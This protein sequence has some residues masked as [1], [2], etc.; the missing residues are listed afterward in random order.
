MPTAGSPSLKRK[1]VVES[2]SECYRRK[3]KC[4]RKQP[5]NNCSVRNVPGKCT[6]N[7]S[8]VSRP[9]TRIQRPSMS[10][11]EVGQGQLPI[12][13]D[14]ESPQLGSG[15]LGYSSV[16]GSNAFVG[17]QQILGN[18]EFEKM[19]AVQSSAFNSR[20]ARKN[21]QTLVSKLPPRPVLQTLVNVFF[22]EVNWH[23]AI[24]ERFYFDDLFSR[25][26]HSE[27]L[28]PVNYLGPEELSRELRYF[29]ALL[30]QV[31]S[32][33]LQVLPPNHL[34]MAQISAD[35]LGTSQTYSDLGDELLSVL[36]RPGATLSGVQADFLRSSWLKNVGRGTEAWHSFGNAIRQAQELGLHRQREI[37]QPDE[38]NISK[39]LSCLW[40][41]ENKKR[42]WINLFVWDSFMAMILGRPRMIHR[43]D[44]DAKPP[45]ECSIPKNP[46]T[47]VPMAVRL[48][49]NPGII[50]VSASLFRYAI[51]CKVHDMRAIKL[52]R[53]HPKVYSTV[54]KIHEDVDLL[55][56]GL[57]PS[58]RPDC[59]DT[60]WDLSFPIFLSYARN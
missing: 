46:S 59:P 12:Q 49:E 48:D 28:E 14:R 1:R 11:N 19:N 58:I 39:T 35:A 33:T 25:W 18:D 51:A 16:P 60:S 24:L 53:P 23:Y 34:D 44:C 42:L 21:A 10:T 7:T 32:L 38:T 40:Y 31:V 9:E 26:P 3:Q 45:M 57:L 55:M 27:E 13:D 4:D 43:D 6:F 15:S 20:V 37:R 29:S 22:A 54:R 30:F 8:T 5:C 2:C 50:P 52:D 56:D 36:G 41:E 17:L 47:A